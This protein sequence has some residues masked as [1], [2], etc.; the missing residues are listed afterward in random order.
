M[1]TR[2]FARRSHLVV[3]AAALFA[4]AGAPP[5]TAQVVTCEKCHANR[6]FLG[7]PG[8]R[9]RRAPRDDRRAATVPAS[10]AATV[11]TLEKGS[12]AS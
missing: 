12:S 5:L 7:G 3:A 8:G 10:A 4:L 2:S 6:D 1:S 11:F 9:D